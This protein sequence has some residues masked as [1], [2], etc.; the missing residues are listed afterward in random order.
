MF[1][2]LVTNT[3]NN[4]D[5]VRDTE[6]YFST[7]F[8]AHTRAWTYAWRCIIHI[9]HFINVKLFKC[10]LYYTIY[11]VQANYNFGVALFKEFLLV[12]FHQRFTMYS[13]VQSFY[14]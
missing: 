4:Y 5:T 7:H 6:M 3:F 9:L 13:F 11:T 14:S 1:I 12:I 2:T 10:L 8:H